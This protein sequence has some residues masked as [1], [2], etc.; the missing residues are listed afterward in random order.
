MIVDGISEQKFW[1]LAM[2]S[3]YMIYIYDDGFC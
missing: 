2:F 3:A 1:C